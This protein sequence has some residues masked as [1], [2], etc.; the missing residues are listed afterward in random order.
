[1]LVISS[2]LLLVPASDAGG[3]LPL[4]T[5]TLTSAKPSCVTGYTCRGFVV[6]GCPNVQADIGG[7]IAQAFPPKG[8]PVR[9]LV[10]FFSGAGGAAWWD[11]GDD[12]GATMVSELRNTYGFITMQARFDDVEWF[13]ASPG[14]DAGLA[15]TACRPATIIRWVYDTKYAPLNITPAPGGCGFCITGN[16]GGASIVS[17][18]LTHYGMDAILNGVIPTSGP[19][20]ARLDKGCLPDY[21]DYNFNAWSTPE[22]DKPF[23]HLDP[24]D[25]GPCVLHDPGEVPRW[26]EESVVSGALDLSYP[27]TRVEIVIGELDH[28]STPY[29]AS[30][31]RDALLGGSANHVIYDLVPDMGHSIGQYQ[32]GIDALEAAILASF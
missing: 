25:P 11:G 21:P 26:M 12:I 30:D 4:G 31:F 28:G 16:S 19:T 10:L 9:G 29:Q 14:E 8:V 2:F 18:A 13:A 23:G 24:G 3:R 20:M 6:S 15:H 22:M 17:Y 32:A 1:M 5:F 7:A 27:N